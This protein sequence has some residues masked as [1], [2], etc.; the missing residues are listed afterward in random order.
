MNCYEERQ[1]VKMASHSKS[2]RDVISVLWFCLAQLSVLIPPA[3]QI[4]RKKKK[5]KKKK[6]IASSTPRFLL[7]YSYFMGG[8]NLIN[9]LLAQ[10]GHPWMSSNEFG[11]ELT[12]IPSCH[13]SSRHSDTPFRNYVINLW[14][15][16]HKEM[17]CPWKAAASVYS[18]NTYQSALFYKCKTSY[19]TMC[20]I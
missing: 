16:S 4:D 13:I 19:R 17:N 11:V 15:P 18:Q 10:W 12:P 3:C 14:P 9:S 1:E 8:M 5:K 20:T 7:F 2:W 6:N